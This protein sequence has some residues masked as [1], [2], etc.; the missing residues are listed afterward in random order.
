[1]NLS[2]KITPDFKGTIAIT[3]YTQEFN[4]Y[5]PEDLETV[6]PRY[7][8]FKYSQTCTINVIR[9]ISSSEEEIIDVIYSNHNTES[10]SIRVPLPKDGH[11]IVDHI[12]LPTIDWYK[13]VQN[14]DLSE[15]VGLYVTNGYSVYKIMED[16]YEEVD[17]REIIEVNPRKTTISCEHFDVFT[18]D[19]LKHCYV[20][21]A[22]SILNKYIDK[23]QI[24]ESS[25]QFNRDFL[26]M[27]INVITYYLEWGNYNEAQLVLEE[28]RCYDFCPEDGLLNTK[29]KTCGCT[30]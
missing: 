15:Y 25:I 19:R 29:K 8:H 17:I 18:I 23:C 21:A 5:I 30:K 1:M 3:D 24:L 13:E 7:Y 12:I 6:L 28:L 4:E 2:V 10:D 27:T 11:Y 14:E 9:Y 16:Q 22:K 26:W 20:N